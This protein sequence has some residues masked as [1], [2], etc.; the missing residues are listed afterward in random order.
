[1]AAAADFA[2]GEVVDVAGTRSSKGVAG[3]MKRHTF[4]GL[5]AT[6]GVSVSHRSHGSP[7]QRQDPGRVCK[8]KRMA[9][10]MGDH[11]VTTQNLRVVAT[12]ADRGLIMVRGAVP[13][14]EGGYV[15]VRDA[16]KRAAPDGL[17]FPAALRGIASG[18]DAPAE[19]KED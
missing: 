6:H 8:G 2:A 13:G 9:G 10:H 11:R 5:R 18:A 14:A 16:A 7:G 19:A 4:G 15:L 12:D 1:V 3:V 17:P